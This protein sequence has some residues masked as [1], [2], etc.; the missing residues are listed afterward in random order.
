MGLM[1]LLLAF[2]VLLAHMNQRILTPLGLFADFRL[3]ISL[4]G[5]ISVLFFLSLIHI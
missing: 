3:S 5:G 1:R 4:A 2:G